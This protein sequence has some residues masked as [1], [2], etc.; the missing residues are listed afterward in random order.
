MQSRWMLLLKFRFSLIPPRAQVAGALGIL[1]SIH[2]N[3]P[4]SHF[5]ATE[6]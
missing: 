2:E 4:C 3:L 1:E 6:R 5:T